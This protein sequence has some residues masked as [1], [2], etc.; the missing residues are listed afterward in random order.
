[1]VASS[2]DE[3][4]IELESCRKVLI[5]AK[6]QELEDGVI[7][8]KVTD[9]VLQPYPEPAHIKL[10]ELIVILL[11]Q[12]ANVLAASPNST[13]PSVASLI[14]DRVTPAL[15]PSGAITGIVMVYIDHPLKVQQTRAGEV[16]AAAGRLSTVVGSADPSDAFIVPLFE[17]VAGKGT[18]TK[19]AI[20]IISELLPYVPIGSVP[21]GLLDDLLADLAVSH[22][23]SP[24]C[25]LIVDLLLTLAG[26]SRSSPSS[27]SSTITSAQ[28]DRILQPLLPAFSP[29]QPPTTLLHL[30]RYL[31]PSLFQRCPTLL[32]PLLTTLAASP[33]LFNAWV[34]VASLGVSQGLVE[35]E[36]LPRIQVELA[37]GS[38][39]AETRLR[40]FELVSGKKAYTAGVLELIKSSFKW[41]EGLPSAG[42]RS[43]FSSA[44]Y[45][46]FV[47]LHQHDTVIN[48][49]LRKLSKQPTTPATTAEIEQLNAS[50]VITGAFHQWLLSHLDG[51]LWH[52]RRYPVF[53]VL[54]ALNL[55]GRYLEVFGEDAGVQVRVYTQERVESLIACQASEFAEVRSRA[56]KIL[57]RATVPLPGYESL[58]TRA[59]QTLLASALSS[60]DQPRKTQAEA[61]KAALCILFGRLVKDGSDA[62]ALDFVQGLV[63]RL[64]KGVELAEKDL[65]A[66]EDYPLHGLLSAIKDLL[67]CLTLTPTSSS[68]WSPLFHGLFSLISRIWGVTRAVISLAPSKLTA[69]D[70]AEL[71]GER[72]DHEIA[73]AYEVL[74]GGD[75]GDDEEGMDHTG[76]LSGCW[77]ATMTAGELLATIITLPIVQRVPD[78]WTREEVD[79]AGQCFLVWLHEIRHRGTFSKIAGAFAQ[80]VDAV[81]G[82]PTL[83]GLC[84]QWLQ[85]ELKAIASDEHST[86]RRSAALPYSILSIVSASA[87]LLETAL[88]A[89]LDLAR[90][91]NTQTSNTTKVHAFNVLKIVLL[92]ARQ[93]KWFDIWFER[94]VLVALRAFESDDWN[95][96]NVGLILFSTLVH[97]CLSPP[98]G[99]QDYY[100]SRATLASRRS[101]SVFHAKYP[102]VLPFITDYLR[103]S[104]NE[105][106]K[107]GGTGKHSPLFPI[108]IIIRS[109]KWS[110]KNTELPEKLVVAV[111]PY[112]SSREYQ[113]RQVAAQALSSVLSP[114]AALDRAL[115]ILPHLSSSPNT[116]HGY[117]LLLRQLLENVIEWSSVP[118]ASQEAIEG[119]LLSLVKEHVP[120]TCPPLTAEVLGCV[121]AYLAQVGVKN[122]ELVDE[123]VSRAKQYLSTTE[124]SFMPAEEFRLSACVSA[125]LAHSPGTDDLLKLLGPQ[126]SEP[127]NLLVLE[128]LPSLPAPQTAEAF[129]RV[130]GL[131]VSPAA[132]EGVQEQALDV[133]AETEWEGGVLSRWESKAS[134]GFEKVCGRL[135]EVVKGKCVPVKE[136]GLA[137]LGWTVHQGMAKGP[138]GWSQQAYN[139]LVGYILES[140][141]EDESQPARF[142]AYRS[143]SYLTPYLVTSPHPALHRAL[144]RL[145]QDD[146]EEI[147]QGAGAIVVDALGGGREVVQ[148]KALEMWYGWATGYLRGLDKDG[149]EMREW[150]VWLRELAEDRQGL[151]SDLITLKGGVTS[152]VLFEIEPSNIFRDSLVDAYHASTLLR[153]LNLPLGLSSPAARTLLSVS[154]S[155][156]DARIPEGPADTSAAAEHTPTPLPDEP[157]PSSRPGDSAVVQSLGVLSAID[158]AWEA[159]RSSARRVGVWRGT[160]GD[161]V[162]VM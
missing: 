32:Q 109:L 90:V 136:A 14:N 54:L 51:N 48:R 96:R 38:V 20:A 80:L 6:P 19:S 87:S 50:L 26:V 124:P 77:R 91:D 115:T 135:E 122:G 93:T 151:E 81:R 36:D 11:R 37:L 15:Q 161:E 130:L 52:A 74:G 45:A 46:F 53:R 69:T 100:R 103:S 138:S 10:L 157:T 75:E 142:A 13:S 42:A 33:P 102:L 8:G 25:A 162:A 30:S 86:T 61:G 1:M 149:E 2:K 70:E 131:A 108:L 63:G 106:G 31:L 29:S 111:E 123:V 145:L 47:R 21:T 118:L 112:L 121:E 35:I 5:K 58:S 104:A 143:L 44:S 79:S 18:P 85:H 129:G 34:A 139:R 89:L 158:D 68:T 101:F 60:L 72:P 62:E 41:N 107:Q 23:A 156:G 113:V 27:S 125:V 9:L 99:G 28:Q 98:R 92:D 73:R 88:T 82:V 4:S 117:L 67:N 148:Q 110:E 114:S 160:A 95:V 120:G 94:G 84:E 153:A 3:V 83:E 76:L 159:R 71:K 43:A 152:D 127:S 126:A 64:E 16:L 146:D 155:D 17:S 59:S 78:M 140:S 144:V 65:V 116:T 147:R 66:I 24:R 55:L 49:T 12:L 22:S 105:D 39:D 97:R 40:G 132:G 134:G 128:R 56:R 57:D 141:H 7:M 150:L 154:P 137:A 119:T 133:L